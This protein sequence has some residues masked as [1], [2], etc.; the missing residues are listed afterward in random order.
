[1]ANCLVNGIGCRKD[2]NEG[3]RWLKKAA[4]ADFLPAMAD[5][6]FSCAKGMGVRKNDDEAVKWLT[7]AAERD[8]LGAVC[9]LANAYSSGNEFV[10]RD[11]DK[12]FYWLKKAARLGDEGAREV[13]RRKN[14][15]W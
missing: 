4:D 14:M 7:K 15:S 5:Y 13:L 6:G 10:R 3:V 8:H 11:M 1:M 2:V 12:A 9:A